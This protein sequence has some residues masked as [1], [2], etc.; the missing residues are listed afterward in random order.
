[1]LKMLWEDTWLY[2]GRLFLRLGQISHERTIVYN[3]KNWYM[4]VMTSRGKKAVWKEYVWV[5]VRV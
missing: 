3:W 1:M 4:Q 2:S 5:C